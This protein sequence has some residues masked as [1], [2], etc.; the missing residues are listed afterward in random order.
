MVPHFIFASGLYMN[1]AGGVAGA[2][3]GGTGHSA[4]G[5]FFPARVLGPQ[6]LA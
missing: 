2:A 5:C 6:S 4:P 3:G 1:V